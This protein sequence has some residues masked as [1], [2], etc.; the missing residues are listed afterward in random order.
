[1]NEDPLGSVAREPDGGASPGWYLPVST[2]CAIGDQT[3]CP[4]PSF[5]HSGT[6]SD[7]MTRQIMLYC[8]WLETMRSSPASAA[9]RSA[10]AISSARHSETPM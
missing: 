1:M 4:I 7:S 3:I 10:A 6:T 9:I 5:S 2:P 8:G